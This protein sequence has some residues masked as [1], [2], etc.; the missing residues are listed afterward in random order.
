MI[1]AAEAGIELIVA[2]TE[3][4]PVHDEAWFYNQLAARLP[5][6]AASSARTARG[7]STAASATSASSRPRSRR[8]GGPVGIVTPLGHAHLPGAERA[9]AEGHRR[10]HVCRHR[11]RPGAGHELHRLPRVVRGRPRD[12]G[13]DHVRRDRRL[14]RGRSGRVHQHEDDEAGRQLH[15]GRDRAARQEDGPRGRD[16]V[17]LEGHRRR[18]RWKRSRPP[19]V[20]V[21]TNPTEAGELMA[22]VVAGL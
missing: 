18:R 12:Q 19:G 8:P 13:R 3:G 5:V 9:G 21:A 15:R 2:V 10:H 11:R 17:G 14:G 16:R 1:E 4:I 20:R 6:V 7:S 22:E